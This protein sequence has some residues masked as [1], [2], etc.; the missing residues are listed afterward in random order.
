MRGR[1][2]GKGKTDRQTGHFAPFEGFTPLPTYAEYSA[3]FFDGKVSVVVVVVVVVV[4]VCVCVF[5]LFSQ[6]I[7]ILHSTSTLSSKAARGLLR[8]H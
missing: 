2:A 3:D 6:Q 7:K 4:G 8:M 1:R 5:M